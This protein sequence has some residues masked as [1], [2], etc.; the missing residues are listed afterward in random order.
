MLGHVSSS[1]ARLW[2]K[3]TGDA[4]WSVRVSE[5]A[6]LAVAREVEGTPL[7]DA[8]TGV[9]HVTGL[10]PGT[11]YFYSVLLDGE[12]ATSRP[13]TGRRLHIQSCEGI[14]AVQSLRR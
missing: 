3:A 11:R 12:P 1:D 6:D 14:A 8:F 2:I 9:A 4:K 5:K 13:W 10:M 7:S